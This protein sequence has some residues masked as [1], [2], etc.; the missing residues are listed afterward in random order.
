MNWMKRLYLMEKTFST[1]SGKETTGD[2]Q[3]PSPVLLPRI[4]KITA[5]LFFPPQYP[6]VGQFF[7][8]LL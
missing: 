8:E 6:F 5:P 1:T 2:G 7:D 3:I 4:K